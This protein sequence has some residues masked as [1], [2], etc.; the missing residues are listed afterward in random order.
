MGLTPIWSDPLLWSE[1]NVEAFQ[2]VAAAEDMHELSRELLRDL[3]DLA[4][5]VEAGPTS[6]TARANSD[7]S[8]HLW[9][10]TPET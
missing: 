2:N 9:R 5:Y 3:L 1:A 10:S 8:R 4:E 6:P 7:G